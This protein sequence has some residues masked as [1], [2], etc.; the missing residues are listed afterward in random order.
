MNL[1]SVAPP[2]RLT[3][4][5]LTASV[6]ATLAGCTSIGSLF[7][8]DKVDYRNTATRAQPLD[9]PPDLTQLARDARYQ[10]Q[11]GVISASGARQ[12]NSAT[13]GTGTGAGEASAG[14][15]AGGVAPNKLDGMRIERDGQQRWLVTPQ[16]PEQVWPLLKAFWDQRGLKLNAENAQ[17]GVMETEWAENKAK[18]PN[19]PIRNTLGRLF[20]NLYDSGERDAY[21]TRVERTTAGSEVYISHRG[22]EEVY[23]SD[24]KE[25]TVWRPRANDPQLEAEVLSSLMLALANQGLPAVLATPASATATAAATAA[26]ASA[27]LGKA[28]IAETP[29]ATSLVIEEPFDRAWRRVGLALDRGGFSVEDRDRASGIYYVRY[30]DPKFAD[31]EEPGW[32]SKLFGDGRNPAAA[33]RY[34]IV[35]KNAAEKTNLSVQTATGAADT[36]DNAKRIVGLLAKDLR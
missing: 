28:R 34:R 1:L 9:V 23:T 7:G 18:L 6:A 4:T 36:G 5:L 25:S 16:T 20:N 15:P 33:V 8:G 19:D 24:R 3:V 21:R 35:L 17:T 27:N 31:K 30:I 11:G 22:M 12:P 29:Q 2:S 26:T 14:G 13:A 32:W 10:P